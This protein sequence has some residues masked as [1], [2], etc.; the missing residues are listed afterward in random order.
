[1]ERT[2]TGESQPAGGAPTW[3]ATVCVAA[4]AAC[5]AGHA[6]AEPVPMRHAPQE[7]SAWQ[8]L[9]VFVE[10]LTG[11]DPDRIATADVVVQTEEGVE[12][13]VP[14]AMS[15]NALLGEVP[16]ALV[17]PPSVS[18]Y[19]RV[20]DEDGVSTTLPPG[21]PEGGV[22]T[23]EVAV[24]PDVRDRFAGG[25]E[26]L[27][28]LPGEVVPA[29]GVEIAGLIEPRLDE[30]WDALLLLDGLDVSPGAEITPDLFVLA[31]S[32]SLSLG[33]HRV[34][35]SA[36]TATTR[37]EESWVFYAG[38]RVSAEE[39]D[40]AAP[41]A[42]A[43]AG[44][45]ERVDMQG[46]L[47]LGW[48]TVVAEDAGS[49]TVKSFLPYEE[50]SM[51]T[52]DFY[53]AG[54]RD[55]LSILL[56]AHYDP[57]YDERLQWFASTQ[58]DR[59]EVEVGDIFPSLS[60]TTLDWAAG[61][62]A[63]V[64]ASV[65][66]TRTEAVGLRISEA[67]TVAGFG[68]YSR[69]ALGA[70]EDISLTDAVSAS[71]V[72]VRVYD[73]EESVP[74]EQRL[75]APL[76]NTVVAGVIGAHGDRA[77]LEVEVA[78]A[79]ATGPLDASGGAVR[80]RLSYEKDY[81]NRVLFEYVY[82]DPTYY[83]AGSLEHEPGERGADLEFSYRP[84]DAVK[85]YGSVGA[86]LA[87]DSAL[88]IASGEYAVKAYGRLDGSWTFDAG[89]LRA[90]GAA[91]YDRTPYESYDYAY[92]YGTVGA[93]WRT[94]RLVVTGQAS[95]SRSRSTD[96]RD[97]WGAGAELR[98][99]LVPRRWK[100]RA[101]AR[102]TVGSGEGAE[103]DYTRANYA[104]ESRWIGRDVEL[105]MEYRLINL[106]DRVTPDAGYTEHVVKVGLGHTF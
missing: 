55:D 82:S 51:P 98:Y 88:G 20:V 34:T 104:L 39:A 21:A 84:W 65:G 71:V 46:R 48:A 94:A 44:R 103:S 56:S 66:R 93:T 37:L 41:T 97:T 36:I 67:D 76:E 53:A 27:S 5:L 28:P 29:S 50:T 24:S 60:P 25:V 96:V 90:Y 52:L 2:T 75:D 62:G 70:R 7:A 31:L 1:M 4:V 10:V 91:R 6:A 68:I 19:I 23:I 72:Y 13:S 92:A 16:A 87:S 78:D 38:E 30:P 99:D 22:F 15:R 61:T 102:W 26:I 14:L 80:A 63:R 74:E 18:Y 86:Y 3:R 83:S 9:G 77:G 101:A 11:V 32:E 89:G 17:R 35:F 79:T 69:F 106:D 47:E 59:Y 58:T 105:S 45:R 81:D 95:F 33:A 73:R 85:A 54:Y 64:A 42:G 100:G 43:P 8:P 12:R 40:R 57:V 49:D